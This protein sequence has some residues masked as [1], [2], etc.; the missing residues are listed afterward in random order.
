MLYDD[1]DQRA[2]GKFARMDLIGLPNQL[3]VGP[4]GLANGEI[5]LKNRASGER[6]TMSIKAA[7]NSLSSGQ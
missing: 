7:I 4:R 5:E 2:G 1:T 3:I 6:Q